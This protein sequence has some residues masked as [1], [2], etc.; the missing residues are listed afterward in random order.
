MLLDRLI[1]MD[2]TGLAGRSEQF[3]NFLTISEIYGLT[4]A[5]VFHTFY[6]TRQHWQIKLSQKKIFSCFPGSVQASSIVRILSSFCNRYE[7]N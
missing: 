6:R 7:H 1:V 2:V 4:C 3:A 5:Y